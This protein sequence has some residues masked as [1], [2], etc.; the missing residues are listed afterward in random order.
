MGIVCVQERYK[1]CY[2]IPNSHS[3]PLIP[4]T[5]R[6]S[7]AFFQH[8]IWDNGQNLALLLFNLDL[9]YY[10]MSGSV[11]D[12]NDLWSNDGNDISGQDRPK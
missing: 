4:E 12:D 2:T 11:V 5:E 7:D 9:R 8:D 6:H 10:R 1:Y 3:E